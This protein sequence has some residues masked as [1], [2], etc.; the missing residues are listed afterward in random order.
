[1]VLQFLDVILF[2]STREVLDSES[3]KKSRSAVV[4]GLTFVS[5]HHR[6]VEVEHWQQKLGRVA[7]T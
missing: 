3:K 4:L 5:L 6:D 7:M 2:L 1:M